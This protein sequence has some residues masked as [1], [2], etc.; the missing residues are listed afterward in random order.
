M[1]KGFIFGAGGAVIVLAAVYMLFGRKA[2]V[3]VE[4]VERFNISSEGL[5]RI[6]EISNKTGILYSEA[7]TYYMLENSFFD[8]R[9]PYDDK[10][11]EDFFINYD[12][13]KSKYKQRQ[14]KPYNELIKRI[15]DDIEAFPVEE[16]YYSQCFYGDSY[17][18]LRT[19]GG[20][21]EHRGTD[22]IYTENIRG[23]VKVCS[24]TDGI[25]EKL[26]WN[27]K[28]GYRA[29][30]RS[31]NNIYYYY[32]HLDSYAEKLC[33]GSKVKAGDFL[34]YMGDSGYSKDEGT[35]GLFP[36]HLHLGIMPA[37][38]LKY[39]ELWINPYPFLK[40]AE[41]EYEKNTEN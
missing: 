17:G 25:V 18:A 32:A 6:S 1:K 39:G 19:Y 28:G 7:V 21:R 24:M 35:K 33:V 31:K 12:K 14:V 10:D 3:P 34:G 41:A 11:I 29:G 13:I 40:Y 2:L 8:E 20:K 27:E 26:G 37:T 15:F 22:I 16:E 23:I 9:L 38:R 4:N 36:V 30:I 5:M